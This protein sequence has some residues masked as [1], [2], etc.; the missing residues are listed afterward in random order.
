MNE[1]KHW[2]F[3][4]REVAR[5]AG[6][7]HN[8]P[9]AHFATKRDLLG[10]IAAAG[11]HALRGRMLDAAKGI[12][13]TRD[14]LS[15]IG[16]AYL[17]FG[18]ENPA[19]YRLMFGPTLLDSDAGQPT[20]TLEAARYSRSVLS[21]VIRRGSIDG[22]FNIEPHDP[23]ALVAGVFAAWSI[24]H[25]LT[26]LYIDGLAADET[27]LDLSQLAEMV[28]RLFNEGLAKR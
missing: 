6:V 23:T 2:D 13:N 10:A 20:E 18:E 17:R 14:E 1:T 4:L 12:S 27:D 25:G 8:A 9:Y 7:T 3:S 19:R 24:V 15:A 28:S 5:R 11:F 22:S 21:D 26:L 16:F